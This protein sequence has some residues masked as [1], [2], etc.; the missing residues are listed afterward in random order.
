[1]SKKFSVIDK[2]KQKEHLEKFKIL[3][4]SLDRKHI[5]DIFKMWCGMNKLD[6]KKRWHIAYDF[7]GYSYI[8]TRN[9]I[10][11]DMKDFEVEYVVRCVKKVMNL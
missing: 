9:P 1:M 8:I 2:E 5:R 6:P 7:E 3:Y 10:F 4:D 11:P